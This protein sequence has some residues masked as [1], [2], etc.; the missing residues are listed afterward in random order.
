[1]V[2]N[3]SPKTPRDT[4]RAIYCRWLD[5]GHRPWGFN[6]ETHRTDLETPTLRKLFA[7]D[8]DLNRLRTFFPD[9]QDAAD[10][11]EHYDLPRPLCAITNPPTRN[12]HAVFGVTFTE[13]EERH[14]NATAHELKRIIREITK[15]IG[16]D[17]SYSN[18][19]IRGPAYVAGHHRLDHRHTITDSEALWHE[20]V[21][22]QPHL[23]TLDELREFVRLLKNIHC[24]TTPNPEVIAALGSTKQ[25]QQYNTLED[26]GASIIPEGNDGERIGRKVTMFNLMRHYAYRAAR[27]FKNRT[28]LEKHLLKKYSAINAERCRPVLPVY[29]I[30]SMEVSVAKFCDEQG[31]IK[32]K[33]GGGG[34]GYLSSEDARHMARC[35]WEVYRECLGEAEALPSLHKVWGGM[36]FYQQVASR[37]CK[38]R[39]RTPPPK[40][41]PQRLPSGSSYGPQRKSPPDYSITVNSEGVTSTDEK[42]TGPP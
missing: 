31:F 33:T 4:I 14:P 9:I 23:Y 18:F 16:A 21:W 2:P 35:R 29:H 13:E 25:Q 3:R 6:K 28:E 15:W 7:L 41:S 8:L 42:A 34:H 10:I 12:A 5:I 22:Y 1:M 40:F 38:T 11:F 36:S 20:T 27:R 30:R 26:D 17:P 37:R 32:P 24:G 39:K 19:Y